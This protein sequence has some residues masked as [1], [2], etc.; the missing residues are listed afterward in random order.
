MGGLARRRAAKDAQ[1]AQNLYQAAMLEWTAVDGALA[2]FAARAKTFEGGIATDTQDLTLQVKG[3]ERVFAIVQNCGLVEARR[4]P[5]SFQGGSQGF[6][7]PVGKTGIRYRVG[8]TRGTFTPGTEHPS[9]VDTGVATVTDRRVVFQGPLQSRE[10]QFSKLLGYQHFDVPTWTAIQVSN[11]QKTSGI[12]YDRGS[13]AE[14]QL[15]IELA[16]AHFQGRVEQ[17]IGQLEAEAA[18]H[19]SERP[20]APSSIA[21]IGSKG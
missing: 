1:R 8:G 7:F 2:D 18:R 20:V 21:D 19:H 12:Q 15:R 5:G 9:V 4:S 10:W 17:L 16:L 14:I 13:A 11:R 3:D 6:S